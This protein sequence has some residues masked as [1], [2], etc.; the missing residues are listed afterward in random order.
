MNKMFF[1]FDK[2]NIRDS[3]GNIVSEQI[4]KS[5]KSSILSIIKKD[6]EV[7]WGRKYENYWNSIN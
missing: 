4:K 7:G 2:W 5:L 6:I 3:S 1:E